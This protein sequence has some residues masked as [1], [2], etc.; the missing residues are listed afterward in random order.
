[1]E[2]FVYIVANKNEDFY[3]GQTNSLERRIAQHN[4]TTRESWASRRGPWKIQYQEKFSSRSEAMKKEKHLKSLKNKDRI[5]KYIARNSIPPK[6]E[7]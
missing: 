4:D 6:R 5:Q 3:I 2:Y 1:M 7:P